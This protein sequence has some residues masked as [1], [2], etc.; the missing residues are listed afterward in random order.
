MSNQSEGVPSGERTESARS[1]LTQEE[2]NKILARHAGWLSVEMGTPLSQCRDD[3]DPQEWAEEA[4][5]N[6]QRA[7]LSNTNLK[8]RTL[9]NAHL[10]GADFTGA[11]F[12]E[13]DLSGAILSGAH[14]SEGDQ[15]LAVQ[16]GVNVNR[17]KVGAANLTGANLESAKLIGANLTG[18]N[19]TG[20]LLGAADLTDAR[21]C[22]ADLRGADLNLADL[23]STD[24]RWAD[25]SCSKLFQANLSGADLRG[26]DFSDA[27]VAFVRWDRARM[28]NKYSGIRIDSCYGNAVFKRWAS[29]QDFLDNLERSWSYSPWRRALFWA[30]GT[31]DYGRSLLKVFGLAVVLI[32]V[33]GRVYSRWP[34]LIG[35]T[36]QGGDFFTP[37]YF[38]IVTFTTLGFGDINPKGHVWGELIV[39][40]EV[41]LG[42]CTLGL[43]L[44]V[45]AEKIARR[46]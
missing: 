45:L 19:L 21:L 35:P 23:S 29:D 14:L 37:F 16:S 10:S 26:A 11:D 6:P 32:V 31:I 15:S 38:S 34:Q 2:L 39:S 22:V 3:L 41:I 17:L 30:W 36:L 12:T 5:S 42:Y 13:A 40:F 20:A 28:R 8:G 4:R 43:L 27:A 33:F 24:L 18:T 9:R 46:S 25:L 1:T 7:D 44:S